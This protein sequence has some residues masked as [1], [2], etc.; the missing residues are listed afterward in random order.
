MKYA[1]LLLSVLIAVFIISCNNDSDPINPTAQLDKW[2]MSYEILIQDTLN[3]TFNFRTHLKGREE[4]PPV[5]TNAQGQAIFRMNR[6]VGG[7]TGAVAAATEA[8]LTRLSESSFQLSPN[9]ELQGV[10][11]AEYAVFQLGADSAAILTS[12]AS[13][14]LRMARAFADRFTELGGTMV[15]VQYYR[16]RDKD[17]GPIVRDIKGMILG[18]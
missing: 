15:A 2:N 1:F 14:H 8:G 4:V 11:M 18:V 12:T 5:S 9:V 10:V 7:S 16:S 3:P 13:E 6:V 17:F